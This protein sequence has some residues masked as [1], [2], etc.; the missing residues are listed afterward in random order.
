MPV[1]SIHRPAPGRP[2]RLLIEVSVDSGRYPSVSDVM[3]DRY[4]INRVLRS[5]TTLP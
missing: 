4:G 5:V 1:N 3:R 2:V